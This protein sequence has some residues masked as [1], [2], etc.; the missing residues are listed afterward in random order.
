VSEASS[1]I[2][3]ADSGERYT[4]GDEAAISKFLQQRSLANCGDFLLPHL[5]A[6]MTVLD[7]GCGPGVLTLGLAEHVTP[8]RVLGIDLQPAA[9]SQAQTSAAASGITNVEFQQADVYALPFP[10]ATFDAV[11]SHALVTHLREPVLALDEARRVL[12]PGG[13]IGVAENDGDACVSSPPGSPAE[14]W[15]ALFLRVMEHNGGNRQYAR[16]LRGALLKAGFERVEGNAG[17]EVYGTSDGLRML[18]AGF[19]AVARRPDFIRTVVSQ[20]WATRRSSTNWRGRCLFG[21]NALMRIW[22]S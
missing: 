4:F 10:D 17:A 22:R 19:A 15:W 20:G 1:R 3:A 2:P 13:V 8:G 9:I 11:F 6:G 16:H 5:R 14:R 18:A 21:A 12:K 7:C